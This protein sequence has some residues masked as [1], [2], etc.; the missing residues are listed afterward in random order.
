MT[1]LQHVVTAYR[2]H[3]RLDWDALYRPELLL[4]A[5]A[6]DAHRITRSISYRDLHFRSRNTEGRRLI[7]FLH[8]YFRPAI[9]GPR[10]Q[11]HFWTGWLSHVIS[12][13]IWRLRLRDDA[14]EMWNAVTNGDPSTARQ[15][16]E[17]YELECNRIDAELFA[18]QSELMEQIR[19]D[20]GEAEP[21]ATVPELG[22][23]DIHDWRITV[24]ESMLPPV[25]E[26]AP[27][28]VYLNS[29]FV[30]ACINQAVEETCQIVE[31]E[32]EDSDL[33]PVF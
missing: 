13:D 3:K 12:D 27:E 31:W 19:T 33:S 26:G 24:V 32:T 8:K 10:D 29:E 25:A 5:V 4:G 16:R 1:P 21:D 23:K 2:V 14:P 28:L 18:E 9:G 17:L 11:L 6:P 15:M 7:D 20:L 30:Q 22:V